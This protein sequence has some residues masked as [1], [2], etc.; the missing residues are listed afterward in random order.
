MLHAVALI[1]G[2]LTLALPDARDSTSGPGAYLDEL[3]GAAGTLRGSPACA[4]LRKLRDKLKGVQVPATDLIATSKRRALS[5]EVRLQL[6]RCGAAPNPTIE[7]PSAATTSPTLPSSRPEKSEESMTVIEDLETVISDQSKICNEPACR[8]ALDALGEDLFRLMLA[9]YV[10]TKRTD[11]TLP[12]LRE[13]LLKS[14]ASQPLL[15]RLKQKLTEG[16]ISPEQFSESLDGDQAIE[17]MVTIYRRRGARALAALL[18]DPKGVDAL[19]ALLRKGEVGIHQLEVIINVGVDQLLTGKTATSQQKENL[20]RGVELAAALS[21]PQARRTL[22]AASEALRTRS[23]QLEEPSTNSR[24][25]TWTPRR[26]KCWFNRWTKRSGPSCWK[27][28]QRLN[29]GRCRTHFRIP[30]CAIAGSFPSSAS[31]CRMPPRQ[32]QS[33]RQPSLPQRRRRVIR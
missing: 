5:A 24:A 4:E 23:P 26:Q 20:R 3:S 29:A 18:K 27:T 1:L 17:I 12:K 2:I 28:W 9:D 6:R 22:L 16:G 10:Q 21:D 11:V 32:G 14:V 8:L 15:D 19:V 13:K 33:S 30:R 31:P 7:K 25:K